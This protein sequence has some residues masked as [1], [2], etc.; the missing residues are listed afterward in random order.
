MQNKSL[1][2]L[3]LLIGSTVGGFIPM[4]WGAGIASFSSIIF[5]GIG[6]ILGI[7]IFFKIAQG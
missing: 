2:W 5:S 7:I 6:G 3:G 4:L 1:V